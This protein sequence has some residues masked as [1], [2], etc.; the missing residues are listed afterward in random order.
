M[1]FATAGLRAVSNG[2]AI[3]RRIHDEL[4]MEI[5]VITG[6]KE[7]RY[8]FAAMLGRFGD[9]MAERGV[10]LDMGG[11]SKQDSMEVTEQEM[12][13][14]YE[15]NKN[16]YDTVNFRFCS[17]Y[18]ADDIEDYTDDDIAAFL[19]FAYHPRTLALEF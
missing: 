1:A 15:A 14:R 2:A 3:A 10:V 13:D 19:H 11:G 6:E 18:Y 8:D 16:D 17:F 7:A 5:S 4:G 9:E 12:R